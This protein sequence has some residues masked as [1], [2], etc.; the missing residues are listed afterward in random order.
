MIINVLISVI[1]FVVLIKSADLFVDGA[2]SFAKNLK[3]PTAVI[4]LTIVSFGTSAPE[5]AV[6]FNSHLS[7]NKD[8]LYGNVIGSNIANI[9]LILGV[10]TLIAPLSIKGDII[11]K[12]IPI[13]LLMTL[14]FSVLFSDSLF[15]VRQAN[16]LT[17]AD[18]I[19]LILLFSVFTYYL[20]T[21]MNRDKRKKKPA[22]DEKPKY[23]VLPA[24]LLFLGG[25]V[26]IIVSSSL[27]VDNIAEFADKIGISQK[28]IS[29]TIV[30]I[31]TSLPELVTTVIAAK[32]GETDIAIGNIVGSNI[33]NICIVLGIP[34]IILGDAASS[35]FG[36]TDTVFLILPVLFL[37]LFSATGRVLKK[38]E[39]VIL[40]I[41]YCAYNGYVLIQ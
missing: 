21:V 1:G 4:G 20:I 17:R 35:A 27:I 7:G 26:G 8:I 19:I 11:K 12:E 36:I 6:A 13:L 3:I 40:L 5:L 28:I 32:K 22:E 38:Y 39:G 24:I 9:L 2:S 41:L 33:F 23:K 37:W 31:G 18:G 15:D 16:T 34:V 14:G 29:V 30:S 25:L 10:A